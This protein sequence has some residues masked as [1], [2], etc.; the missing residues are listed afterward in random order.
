MS[1]VEAKWNDSW[2]L[3][4]ADSRLVG[5]KAALRVYFMDCRLD[6]QEEQSSLRET[7]YKQ[8]SSVLR[9]SDPF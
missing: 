5:F 9:Q 1:T 3:L 2:M 8:L 4:Q 6:V 7:V